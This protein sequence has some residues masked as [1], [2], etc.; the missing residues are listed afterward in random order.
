MGADGAFA[1]GGCAFGVHDNPL[2]L[3]GQKPIAFFAHRLVEYRL[4]HAANFKAAVILAKQ[5]QS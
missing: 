5:P 3:A 1:G 2:F 4:D